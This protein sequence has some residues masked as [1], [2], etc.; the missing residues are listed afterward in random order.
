MVKWIND[1]I[2]FRDWAY[3]N[4]YSDNLT[5]DRIDSNGDYEPSNCRWISK[6]F[7]NE[8]SN[9]TG[10]K[11]QAISPNGDIFILDEY[12]NFCKEHGLNKGN[13]CSMIRGK[14]HVKSVKG[15]KFSVI[16]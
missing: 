14:N 11:Y 10:E 9:H 13:V 16:A 2:A 15:W 1:F 6:A 8:L 5:I 7:N 3:A 4:G 12:C